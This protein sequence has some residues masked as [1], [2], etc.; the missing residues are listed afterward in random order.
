MWNFG[1]KERGSSSK[2]HKS[3]SPRCADS[4]LDAEAPGVDT[5]GEP[6]RVYEAAVALGASPDEAVEV[7]A[8][9]TDDAAAA[10]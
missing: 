1:P 6:T 5:A 9:V 7:V 3:T 10:A 4:G 2:S 8:G